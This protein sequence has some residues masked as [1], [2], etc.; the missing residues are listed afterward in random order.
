LAG[1]GEVVRN[2]GHHFH[3]LIGPFAPVAAFAGSWYLARVL[4]LPQEFALIPFS[5]AL[6]DDIVELAA[7]E[8]NSHPRDFERLSAALEMVILS[9]RGFQPIGYFETDYHGGVG[10]QRA[11]AWTNNRVAA[12]P[13]QCE[14]KWSA[15]GKVTIPPGESAISKMLATLG[16]WKKGGCDCFDM[17]G[18]DQF[19]D[20]S[21]FDH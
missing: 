11:I 7:I 6:H 14:M 3:A 5:A 12:G 16:V 18:L 15:G 10:F 13:F 8:G 2:V 21:R 20:T 1:I 17:L 9:N 19:R 4:T